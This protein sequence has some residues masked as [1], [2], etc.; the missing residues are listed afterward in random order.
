M[1]YV[2]YIQW[3]LHEKINYSRIQVASST[4]DYLVQII[5]VIFVGRLGTLQLASVS[6]ATAVSRII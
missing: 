1:G 5:P 6:L 2:H 3:I 4:L